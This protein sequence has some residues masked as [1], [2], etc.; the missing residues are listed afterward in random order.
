MPAKRTAQVRFAG[1]STSTVSPSVLVT[2]LAE[3][4]LSGLGR[5]AV[6]AAAE[7][8][9]AGMRG[10]AV[11]FGAMIRARFGEPVTF[12]FTSRSIDTVVPAGVHP[13]CFSG[14]TRSHNAFRAS[15]RSADGARPEYQNHLLMA[16]YYSDNSA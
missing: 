16:A 3:N 1:V 14:G 8:T 13:A 4:L 9:G 7:A 5:L 2:T 6:T 15:D 11:V 12:D 10:T